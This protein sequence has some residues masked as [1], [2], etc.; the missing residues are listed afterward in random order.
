[1]SEPEKLIPSPPIVRVR[2]ARNLKERRLLRSLLRLSVRA[3]EEL[4]PDDGLRSLPEPGPGQ[5]ERTR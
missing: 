4:G 1:M 3:D 5:E 2:L